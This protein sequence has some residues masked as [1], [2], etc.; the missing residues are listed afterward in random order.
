MNLKFHRIDREKKWLASQTVTVTKHYL[1]LK[2]EAELGK[3]VSTDTINKSDLNKNMEIILDVVALSSLTLL[4]AMTF[5]IL[6]NYDELA[7][8]TSKDLN[9]VLLPSFLD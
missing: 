5:I 1:E 9:F 7:S 2:V 6:F 3:N 4:F 8:R